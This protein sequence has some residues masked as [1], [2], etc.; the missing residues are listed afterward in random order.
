MCRPFGGNLHIVVYGRL[1]EN[2]VCVRPSEA[3]ATH[4]C[5]ASAAIASPVPSLRRD[6]KRRVGGR[7][8]R[9]EFADVEVWWNVLAFKTER[10]FDEPGDTGSRFEVADVGLDRTDETSL[11]R[12]PILAPRP[13]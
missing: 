7:K 6:L 12:R 1:F 5:E 8:T 13:R 10:S 9:V 11:A 2:D 3:E 4:A